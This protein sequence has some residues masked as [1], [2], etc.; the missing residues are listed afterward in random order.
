MPAPPF[1]ARNLAAAFLLGPWTADGLAR[2]AARACGR[3]R[4]WFRPLARR[5]L[6]AF[7]EA[8]ADLTPERL[9]AFL[10][11][12]EELQ[13][14][15]L[16][17]RSECD[18]AFREVVTASPKMLPSR[19]DVPA[20]PT[21]AALAGW[22]GLSLPELDWFAGS[23]ASPDPPPGPLRHYQ[24]QWVPKRRGKFRLLEIPKARL[25]AIQRRLLHE[26][27]DRIPPHEA[28]HAYRR[29]RSV[30]TYAAPHANRPVVLRFDL[31]DFFPSVPVARV[32]A[33]FRAAGYPAP[34][35]RLLAGLC[36]HRTPTDVLA[37][38]PAALG[39]LAEKRYRAA[40]LPQGAPT[41]PALANLRAFRLDRRLAALANA[42]GAAY[43]RY[44]DDLAF[45]G[46]EA[47]GRA[48]RHFRVRVAEI[49]MEEGFEPNLRKSRRMGQ[50]VRQQLAGVVVNV[51]PNVGRD[52]FDR[53]KAILTNCV[54]HGPAGQNR[55]GRADF[56]A[57]LGGRVAHVAMINPSRGARL[58]A[59]FERI[60]WGEAG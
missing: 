24:H 42:V 45:S 41:S 21:P 8:P 53:L 27:L 49:V 22:L 12:D 18:P 40:H 10:A 47:F 28:A 32:R 56:R 52:E 5:L 46:G 26:L 2:Q 15:W 14:H 60:N 38:A 4:R 11:A 51:R 23:R 50:S 34:V 19:W 43:T 36:T 13:R 17:H 54:R 16:A 37:S 30:L 20:L 25:K 6:A 59:L 58:R 48:F 3:R 39:T 1:H 44:A 9:A 57:Y 33:V 55:D 29:G 35:A 7:G 31:R